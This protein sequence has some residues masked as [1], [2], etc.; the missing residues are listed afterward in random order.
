MLDLDRFKAVNDTHGH[1]AGDAVLAAFA[2]ILLGQVRAS[3]VLARVGGEEF[4]L[5]APNSGREETLLLAERLRKAV[6]MDS[7]FFGE[8]CLRVTVSIG[9][10][11]DHPGVAGYEALLERADQALYN[12]KRNGRNRVET[13]DAPS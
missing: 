13:I 5:L 2:R 4:V 7:I 9:A 10:A 3:D 1:A 8:L 11:T 6:E 12:A